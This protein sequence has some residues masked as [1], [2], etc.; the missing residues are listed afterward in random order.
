MDSNT[1]ILPPLPV[2]QRPRFG[3]IADAEARSGLCRG[4]VYKIAA[5]HPGLFKK[6]GAATIV[7]LEFLERILAALPPAE[8]TGRKTSGSGE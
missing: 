8:I 3:R 5:E 4:M 6:A 1:R 2:G 7:D